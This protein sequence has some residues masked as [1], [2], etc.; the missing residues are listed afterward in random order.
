MSVFTKR[1]MKKGMQCSVRQMSM[2]KT[3][4]TKKKF[5]AFLKEAGSKT[6]IPKDFDK[7]DVVIGL[8]ENCFKSNCFAVLTTRIT[9]HF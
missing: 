2:L 7:L 8:K 4:Q 5:S 1:W 9:F 6:E 3:L